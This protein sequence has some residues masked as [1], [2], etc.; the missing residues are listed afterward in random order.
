MRRVERNP[1]NN[2]NNSDWHAEEQKIFNSVQVKNHNISASM[3]QQRQMNKIILKS[4]K[5][6]HN[7]PNLQIKVPENWI[8]DRQ[9][10]PSNAEKMRKKMM[11]SWLAAVENVPG[12]DY[13]DITAHFFGEF[14]K[15]K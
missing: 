4:N 12:V 1:S 10:E 5:P 3:A 6:Q 14:H 15:V 7:F 13:E 9:N 11:T 8:R 2:S